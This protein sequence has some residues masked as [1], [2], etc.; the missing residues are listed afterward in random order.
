[1]D[2]KR[3]FGDS[4]VE[5]RDVEHR[6]VEYC[7][8]LHRNNPNKIAN[9]NIVATVKIVFLQHRAVIT[10]PQHCDVEHRAVI[11]PPQQTSRR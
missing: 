7:Y 6:D 1:M 4:D 3:S 11:T 9:R 10:P 8:V 5:P 2:T